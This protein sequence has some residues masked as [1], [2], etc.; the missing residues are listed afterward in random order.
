MRADELE[1]IFGG[2]VAAS[3]QGAPKAPRKPPPKAPSEGF[4]CP[5]CAAEAREAFQTA[6]ALL[7]HSI[8]AHSGLG[9]FERPATPVGAPAPAAGG[10]A[11]VATRVD[12][13]DGPPPDSHSAGRGGGGAG[14]DDRGGG[15]GVGEIIAEGF[16]CPDCAAPF[17]DAE[18]LLAHAAEAHAG[19]QP[20]GFVS[21]GFI[22]PDCKLQL[23]DLEALLAH[24][25][26]AHGCAGGG[27][28][29]AVA[30]MSGA[31]AKGAAGG[32]AAAPVETM[33]FDDDEMNALDEEMAGELQ[34]YEQTQARLSEE[35]RKAAEEKAAASVQ[36]GAV[37]A[38]LG[39]ALKKRPSERHDDGLEDWGVNIDESID[40]ESAGGGNAVVEDMGMSDSGDSSSGDDSDC[41]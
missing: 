17:A 3:P 1:D 18:G 26:S 19:Q 36:G 28:G 14:D 16:I 20:S 31:A 12:L 6:E 10:R 33:E 29:G 41:L 5:D 38:L 25:A 2:G 9:S 11:V 7:R 21:E 40:G 8:L 23:P 32:G 27:G 37:K 35:E 22:C 30:L 4:I 13:G 24:C 34:Q 39:R 15:A